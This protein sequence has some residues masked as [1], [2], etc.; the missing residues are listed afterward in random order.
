METPTRTATSTSGRGIRGGTTRRG[1]W[2]ALAALVLCVLAVGLDGTVLTVALP[3][4]AGALRAGESELQWFTSGY[5]L[6]LAA[7]M[8]PAGQLADRFGRKTVLLCS[9]GL[10]AGGSAACAFATGPGWFIAARV[11]LGL[12]GA[13]VIVSALAVLTV[14]FDEDERP[15]AVGLFSAANFLSLPLGPLLGGW[16][17]THAWWGWVFLINVPLAAVG[18]LAGW[19]L[20]PSSRSAAST[21]LDARG[22][23]VSVT[24]LILLTL[25]LIEAGQRGWTDAFAVSCMAL[26]LAV[27]AAFVLLE[28]R[29]ARSRGT[30]MV[31]P[32]L[33]E[34]RSYTWG[35]ILAAVAV[36]AMIG[37]LFTLPQFFQGVLGVS[38]AE[39]GLRLVPLIVGIALAAIPADRIASAVGRKLVLVGGFVVLATGLTIGARTTVHS[40]VLFVAGWTLIAGLGVGLTVA[41]S[42]SAALSA[43]SDEQSGIGSAVLQA[44]N[45]TGAPFGAALL[46][47]VLSVCYLAPSRRIPGAGHVAGRGCGDR[48]QRPVRR[49][50]SREPVSV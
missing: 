35:V 3:T 6:V 50:P 32:A 37:V 46:G 20:I 23:A 44:V 40:P 38:A 12:G 48:P 24:G 11:L 16:I 33:F 26:G 15:R 17:L 29:T 45:K 31:D 8:L 10:F 7:A 43:L 2:W 22:I 4:L 25:G 13:G 47:S 21:A 34:D 5:L 14:L 41:T 39:S 42:T 27:V 28:R 18:L 19:A 30:P 9:L 1:R 36:L 49:A